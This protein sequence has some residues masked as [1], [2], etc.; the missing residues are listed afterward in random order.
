M[1]TITRLS[2]K[3][4]EFC[5]MSGYDIDKIRICITSVSFSVEKCETKQEMINNEVDFNLPYII[6]NPLHF[7]ICK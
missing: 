1:K 6:I 2:K 4:I 7:D 5:E 3:A